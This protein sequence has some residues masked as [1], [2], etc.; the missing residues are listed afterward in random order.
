MSV[1]PLSVTVEKSRWRIIVLEN[2]SRRI[3]ASLV[4]SLG[5]WRVVERLLEIQMSLVEF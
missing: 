2:L 5:H 4:E 3:V 1:S